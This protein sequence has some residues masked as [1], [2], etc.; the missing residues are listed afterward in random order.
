MKIDEDQ[1]QNMPPKERCLAVFNIQAG[2]LVYYLIFLICLW[3]N[4]AAI[5]QL[6]EDNLEAYHYVVLDACVTTMFAVYALI[7]VATQEKTCCGFYVCLL[8]VSIFA[9]PFM[10][11]WGKTLLYSDEFQET[12]NTNPDLYLGLQ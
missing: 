6:C 11:S 8:I 7:I 3:Q 2:L 12:V 9:Y 5:Y 10:C 4:K 1:L